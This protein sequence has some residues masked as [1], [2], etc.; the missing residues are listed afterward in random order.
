MTPP[1]P[2]YVTV[3]PHARARTHACVLEGHP[4]P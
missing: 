2:P 4:G 1:W 3:Q